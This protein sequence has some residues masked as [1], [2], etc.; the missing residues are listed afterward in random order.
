MTTKKEKE[1]LENSNSGSDTDFNADGDIAV[2][3]RNC[4]ILSI[5]KIPLGDDIA[6]FRVLDVCDSYNTDVIGRSISAD[7]DGNYLIG[8][9]R[10]GKFYYALRSGPKE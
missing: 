7:K 6:K 8:G 2:L 10:G 1:F 3:N 4:L 5:G 9:S